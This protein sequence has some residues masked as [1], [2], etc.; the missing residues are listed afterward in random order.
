MSTTSVKYEDVVAGHMQEFNVHET[1][2]AFTIEV[3]AVIGTPASAGVDE[4]PGV[5]AKYWSFPKSA[6]AMVFS[7]KRSDAP[8]IFDF[9]QSAW[10]F[11]RVAAPS[12]HMLTKMTDADIKLQAVCHKF[13]NELLDTLGVTEF[14]QFAEL[15]AAVNLLTTAGA[16]RK[17]E[18]EAAKAT[19][20]AER[21]AV[22]DAKAAEGKV[23]KDRIKVE[24]KAA[25][26]KE[27]A[28][29][30]ATKKIE[31]DKEK[32][33]KQAARKAE[34]EAALAAKPKP[35]AKDTP[36]KV[37]KPKVEKPA[38]PLTKKQQEAAELKRVQDEAAA[39]AATKHEG[40][41]WS[42]PVESDNAADE[43]L[44]DA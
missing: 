29:A 34:A 3:P 5:P 35:P 36:V 21:K 16:I 7:H 2:D 41:G 33:D 38:K 27:K 40:D 31:K 14:S 32:A 15:Q 13:A 20:Q 26:D 22:R 12:R 37:E 44:K 8:A 18:T 10:S 43:L 24:K 9:I 39:K 25:K 4:V 42:D 23:E 30:K 19:K 11:K 1:P 17:A 6:L 28:D